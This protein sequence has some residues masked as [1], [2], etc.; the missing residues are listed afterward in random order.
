MVAV[1]MAFVLT[2]VWFGTLLALVLTW[3]LV[4]ALVVALAVALA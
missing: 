2:D 4:M 3:A 1:C